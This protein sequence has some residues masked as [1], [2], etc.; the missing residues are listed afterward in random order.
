MGQ[1]YFVLQKQ[2]HHFKIVALNISQVQLL[3]M[4]FNQQKLVVRLWN[5]IILI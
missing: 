3:E 1:S 5:F 2:S 4:G